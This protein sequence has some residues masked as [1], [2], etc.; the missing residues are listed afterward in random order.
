MPYVKSL[1]ILS[2]L[3]WGMSLTSFAQEVLVTGSPASQSFLREILSER[4][5]VE[6]PTHDLQPGQSWTTSDGRRVT[7][8]DWRPPASSVAALSDHPEDV[9]HRG[10]LFSGGLTKH[11]PVRFQ[12]YH[13][14]SLEGREPQ[15]AL[16]MTNHG[17]QAATF[18][19]TKAAGT[20]SGDYFSTGHQN[21]VAWFTRQI[22]GEGEFLTLSP[23]E[24]SV[25]YRQPMPLDRVVSGTLG[26]TLVDGP[27][28]QFYLLAL[29][30]S[31]EQTS[32]NNLLKESDVH[33]R[34]FYPVATQ[35]LRRRHLVGG[36]ETLIA[37]GALRQETFAGV[38][39]LRGDYGVVYD[40]EVEIENPSSEPAEVSLLLN[41]RGGAAT[42]TFLWDGRIVEVPR[43]AAFAEQL[44][45]KVQ[46]PPRSRQTVRLQTIPEGASSY[47]VRLII[48]G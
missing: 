16:L 44:I 3:L 36:Q 8:L 34:G 47:P 48:K 13:L 38:R 22:S 2:A 20:P 27:P 42:A 25:V 43:T 46:M 15:V 39:E 31:A 1:A 9:E 21:N 32:L 45:G 11:R 28:I 24:S 19:L 35:H 4:K 12:Y 23:G 33:S 30:D 40:I 7:N 18:H 10:M 6:F 29:P 14:G 17:T 26:L 5:W 41:P 37:V